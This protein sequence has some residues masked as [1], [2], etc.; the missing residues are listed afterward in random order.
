MEGAS[1]VTEDQKKLARA[2]AKAHMLPGSNTGGFAWDMDY[3]ASLK[4]PKPL[5]P[6]QAE[7]L[8]TAVIRFRRSIPADVVALAEHMGTQAYIEELCARTRA[9]LDAEDMLHPTNQTRL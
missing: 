9:E 6:G 8:R 1:T 7:Y 4:N 2:L 5:T 3:R